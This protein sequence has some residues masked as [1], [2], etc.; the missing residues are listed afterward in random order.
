MVLTACFDVEMLMAQKG[1]KIC[2]VLENHWG[3]IGI[4]ACKYQNIIEP[5]KCICDSVQ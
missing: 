5:Q 1:L 4:F 2:V 3:Q